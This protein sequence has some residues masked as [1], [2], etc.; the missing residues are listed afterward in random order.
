[1]NQ[2]NKC[3]AG[4]FSEISG[5]IDVGTCLKCPAGTWSPNPGASSRSECQQC[6][7]GTYNEQVGALSQSA[8]LSCPTGT[9]GEKHAAQRHEDCE[10]CMAGKYQPALGQSNHTVCLNCEP[11]KYSPVGGVAGCASC[12]SGSWSSSFQAT[13]CHICP[14]GQWT[15]GDGSQHEPDCNPCT[16]RGDR[17]CM[18]GATARVTIQVLNVDVARISGSQSSALR[19]AL[20]HSISSVLDV[21]EASVIDLFGHPGSS[22]LAAAMVAGRRGLKITSFVTVP[23]GSSA[24]AMAEKLY[25]DAMR[26]LIEET[27]RDLF[28]SS[29]VLLGRVG[30]QAVAIKPEP[31]SPLQ[32][33]TTLTTSTKTTISSTTTQPT[34][35]TRTQEPEFTEAATTTDTPSRGD[36]FM[37]AAAP[38]LSH[39]AMFMWAS[40]IVIVHNSFF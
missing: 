7:P 40:L 28:G 11:G 37:G 8:C 26:E 5:A 39:R 29:S 15:F 38:I 20:A 14:V 33:T 21:A 3:V 30:V 22:T 17:Y 34:T 1:M 6:S 19:T 2:C 4:T 32:P 10:P 35:A 16:R 25:T 9:Y 13:S 27:I 18:G 24:N 23:D 12:P 31:F 36:R